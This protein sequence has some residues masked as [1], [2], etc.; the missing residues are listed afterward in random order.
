LFL[1]PNIFGRVFEVLSQI[2]NVM[3]LFGLAFVSQCLTAK[4]VM[5]GEWDVFDAGSTSPQ[6]VQLFYFEFH[7]S[8]TVKSTLISTIWVS[9]GASRDPAYSASPLLLQLEI[10]F[11]N[12]NEF[13]VKTPTNSHSAQCRFFSDPGSDALRSVI[14]FIGHRFEIRIE[15]TQKIEIRVSD[16]NAWFVAKLQPPLLPP[17]IKPTPPPKPGKIALFVENLKEKSLEIWEEVAEWPGRAKE[18]A[19][20]YPVLV[21][22]AE[23]IL[24]IEVFIVIVIYLARRCCR[25]KKKAPA[26]PKPKQE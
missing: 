8:R 5:V 14:D 9:D 21:M 25:T 24:G 6:S 13:Q 3:L 22:S 26:K 17:N 23:A 18:L 19:A 1:E 16:W 11:S 2:L 4:E 12:A 7:P 15:S 20:K 10:T